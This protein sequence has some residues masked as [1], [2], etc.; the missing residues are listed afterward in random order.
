MSSINCQTRMQVHL[1]TYEEVMEIDNFWVFWWTLM[2]SF[3][4]RI[5]MALRLC[6]IL[7]MMLV[8]VQVMVTRWVI[9]IA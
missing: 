5:A 2:F 1:H 3:T 7:F 8:Q 4:N 9:V 6:M